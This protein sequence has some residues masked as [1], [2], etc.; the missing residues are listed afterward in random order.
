MNIQELIKSV[1]TALS[2]TVDD[3]I[4]V[5]REREELINLT[6]IELRARYAGD[7]DLDPLT[8]INNVRGI[9]KLWV[10][11]IT[12]KAGVEL[13]QAQELQ[14]IKQGMVDNPN[15][16]VN[17]IIAGADHAVKNMREKDAK[18]MRAFAE[19]NRRYAGAGG[20]AAPALNQIDSALVQELKSRA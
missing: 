10:E 6:A 8:T 1:N 5:E 15:S 14:L 4:T 13:T 16:W 2:S 11:R 12:E 20:P 3:A 18:L 7:Y 17:L 9:I 19:R